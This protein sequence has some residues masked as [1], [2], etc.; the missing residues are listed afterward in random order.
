MS[1]G[2]RTRR[3]SYAFG[4]TPPPFLY[5]IP[6][7]DQ[8]V[9]FHQ[10]Q[11]LLKKNNV[12]RVSLPAGPGI[13]TDLQLNYCTLGDAC[14]DLQLNYCTLGDACTDL[15][16]NYLAITALNWTKST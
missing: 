15:D 8:P 1:Q 9:S 2:W 12:R 14:T 13:S 3:K 16:P 5:S 11:Q 7:T 10:E 4:Q 6:D